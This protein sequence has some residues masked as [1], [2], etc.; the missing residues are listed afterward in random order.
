MTNFPTDQVE[1]GNFP[2]L[3]VW[4]GWQREALAL[5]QTECRPGSTYDVVL[6]ERAISWALGL[7]LTP[8]PLSER[9]PAEADK[10]DKGRCWYGAPDRNGA[11]ASLDLESEPAIDCTHWLPF[12]A[13]QIPQDKNRWRKEALTQLR[14][15]ARKFRLGVYGAEELEI[16][17]QYAERVLNDWDSK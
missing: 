4:I 2:P 8:I 9:K 13:L 1:N 5:S 14:D 17:E 15:A 7:R 6:I 16:Y 3:S 10:D 11:V 12:H